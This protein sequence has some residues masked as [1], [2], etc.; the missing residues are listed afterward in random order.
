MLIADTILSEA[1]PEPVLRF[2]GS[3]YIL[4]VERFSFLSYV[5]NNIF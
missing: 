4:M 1:G 5:Q 3:Q 2:G